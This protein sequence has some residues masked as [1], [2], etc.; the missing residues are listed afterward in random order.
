MAHG[1]TAG[2]AVR[3][4]L[5]GLVFDV[6]LGG[7]VDGQPVL[8]LHG[9]PQHS[10]MWS[11]VVP[12]LHAAGLR[13]IALDQRGYSPGARP[14]DVDDYRMAECVADA[15]ALLDAYGIETAHVVGHDWGALVGW[16]LAAGHPAR[17]RALT[18]LSVPHPLALSR[19]IATD[20]DQRERSAYI[21]LFRQPGRAEEV[22]LRDGAVRLRAIFAPI[23]GEEYVRPV[24]APGALTA[25]L[26]WYRAISLTEVGLGP[27][28]V[29]T[30]YLWGDRDLAVGGTAAQAC[31]DHVLGEYRFV[32]LPG[33]S[34]WIP[35]E[36]PD[37]VSDAVLSRFRG[38]GPGASS[39]GG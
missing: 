10:G 37:A 35:D 1:G 24:L 11:G 21:G 5:R 26:N 18:A 4:A 36:V 23:E 33:V 13:T 22:L 6:R 15:I 19:A 9:F 14:S 30:T 29:P 39:A 7:P 25:A 20:P 16:H 34:H 31:A 3:V 12:A 28:A 2:E 17:V 38:G 27:V 8:L 32:A